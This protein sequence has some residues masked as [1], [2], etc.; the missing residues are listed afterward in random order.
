MKQKIF[1]RKL[2]KTISST[3]KKSNSN[4]KSNYLGLEV[5]E[6]ASFFRV[7]LFLNYPEKR[8]LLKFG[9]LF[10]YETKYTCTRMHNIA[11]VEK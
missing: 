5:K 3:L 10:S 9:K 7:L 2:K 6:K 8:T 4:Y 1:I 11:T